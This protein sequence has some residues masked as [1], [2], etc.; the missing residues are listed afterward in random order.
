MNLASASLFILALTFAGTAGAACNRPSAP[1]S[2][3]DGNTAPREDMVAAFKTVADYNTQMTEYLDCIKV[4]HDAEVKTKKQAGG[5]LKT[6]EEREY[7]A[8]DLRKFEEDFTA[9]HNAAYDELTSVVARFN[10]QKAVFNARVK[11]EKEA[12]HGQ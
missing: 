3:P 8:R 12:G 1:A 7:H 4:D 9:Q 5:K 6:A 10:E 11:K 2:F